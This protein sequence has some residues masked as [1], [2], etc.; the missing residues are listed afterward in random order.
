M[1]EKRTQNR[2]RSRDTSLHR[3]VRGHGRSR[4]DFVVTISQRTKDLLN[5]LVSFSNGSLT[6]TNDLATIIELS[7]LRKAGQELADLSFLAKFLHRTHGIMKRIGKDGEGYDR[8]A[9]E[10]GRN[11]RK[12]VDLLHTIVSA[13]PADVKE[14][15]EK[16]YLAM[17]QQSLHRL[18]ALM[19]DLSWYKN[20]L[21]DNENRGEATLS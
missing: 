14:G 2:C 1:Y 20:W 10:F 3:V 12:V 17:T 16:E 6:C 9:E 13:A 15:F 21:I 5:T 4:R 19:Y 7:L 8:L 18:L 11:L